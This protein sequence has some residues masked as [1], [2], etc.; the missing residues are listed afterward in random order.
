MTDLI[1][2]ITVVIQRKPIKH[3]YFRLNQQGQLCVSAPLLFP[4]KQLKTLIAE[5][6][7]WI[8]E[9]QQQQRRQLAAN[10]KQQLLLWG[11]RYPIVY[12]H[13]KSAKIMLDADVCHYHIPAEW[14]E[15]QR[16]KLLTEYYRAALMPQVM[17]FIRHYSPVI[18]V[19]VNEARSKVM[20]TRWGSCNIQ[21]QRLWF[22]VWLAKYP[23]SCCEYVVVHEMT[24]LLER[25]HNRRFYRLVEQAMPDWKTWHDYLRSPPW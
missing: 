16:D 24:H 1:D 13:G 15:Q 9:K 18:G 19:T 17:K 6:S 23:L 3:V 25:Y 11:S 5:K 2:N 12:Q 4:E 8:Q 20:K 7:P 22:S 10:N 21:K 14:T